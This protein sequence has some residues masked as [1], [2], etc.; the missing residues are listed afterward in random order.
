M[1]DLAILIL[2]IAPLGI[3]QLHSEGK[4]NIRG[5]FIEPLMLIFNLFRG[6]K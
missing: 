6:D 1:S 2:V 4:L 5:V 3:A